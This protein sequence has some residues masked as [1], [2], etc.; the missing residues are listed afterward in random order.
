MYRL[1]EASGGG[2][3]L[4]VTRGGMPAA[5]LLTLVGRFT[6]GVSRPQEVGPNEHHGTSSL[7]R[8]MKDR[9]GMVW[10]VPLGEPGQLTNNGAKRG[11]V[12]AAMQTIAYDSQGSRRARD[13]FE[14]TRSSAERCS[15]ASSPRLRPAA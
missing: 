7:Q 13:D 8:G 2:A 5:W 4:Y 12:G 1:R 6:A 10:Q 15:M 9:K 11:K 14:V 3:L